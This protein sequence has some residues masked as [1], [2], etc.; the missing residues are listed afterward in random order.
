MSVENA[1]VSAGDHDLIKDADLKIM[2][3]ER[4]ALVGTNGAG[5]STFLQC[6]SGDRLLAEGRIV[7]KAGTSIGYLRQTAVSGSTRTVWEEAA[8]QMHRLERATAKLEQLEV[9]CE[10]EPTEQNF[11]LLAAAT[12]EWMAAGG[13]TR[14]QK[15]GRVLEGLGFPP[16]KYHQKCSEFSGG[17]QMRIALARLLLSEPSALL[18][19]EPTNHL[20]QKAKDW[21]TDY[22][23]QYEGAVVLVS[24]DEPLLDK[25]K[26]HGVAEIH[27]KKVH[28]YRGEHQA[29]LSLRLERAE[30]AKKAYEAQQREI[31]HMEKFI[32][33]FGAKATKASAAQSRVKALEKM[34]RLEAPDEAL[35]AGRASRRDP[36]FRLPKPP[37]CAAEPLVLKNARFG[38]NGNTILRDCDLVL[39]RGSRLVVVGPNGAGK[40]T[41]LRALS[42][43]LDLLEGS[44]VEGQGV[45]LGIFTQDLAQDLPMDEVAMDH[46]LSCVREY[47]SE[48]SNQD[49]RSA[50]GAL[51]LIG[52]M[53]QRKIGMLSGGEKARVALAIFCLVPHNVLILDEPSNH[54]DVV[55]ANVLVEALSAFPGTVVVV[56]HNKEFC[57]K[58][59]PTH[60]GVVGGGTIRVEERGLNPSDWEFG[61]VGAAAVEAS[62]QKK[63]KKGKGKGSKS[64]KKTQPG[65]D[66]A[67]EAEAQEVKAKKQEDR[68]LKTK[69]H[70]ARKRLGKI[71]PSIEKLEKQISEVDAKML[72]AGRDLD[73]LTD[74]Q[75][76]KEQMEEKT[77]K[78]YA[79]WEEL[80]ELIGSN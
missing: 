69:L 27:S 57:E 79:E 80:E 13:P 21:L 60:V 52:D 8:S 24:H 3:G 45:K 44:R 76:K 30:Q 20:D 53:S 50:M 14:D 74:L 77:A 58:L 62:P 23:S 31:E 75:A 29:F 48:I 65:F 37:P 41:F 43:R 26:L 47:N 72:E 73:M 5:K 38:W 46:V 40:S 4:V 36:V 9:D 25:M 42:G 19:D 15:I 63:Q 61:E 49:A 1:V 35:L 22:L 16:E 56:T 78:L 71:E 70:N 34:E 51:G 2:P 39:E 10:R 33:T 64:S 6:L 11:E 12:D 17:W 66:K 18:L 54:L 32:R 7:I 55:T 68:E 28:Y 67:V 59:E